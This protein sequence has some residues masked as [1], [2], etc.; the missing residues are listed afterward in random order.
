[1]GIPP[2][3][4]LFQRSGFSHCPGIVGIRTHTPHAVSSTTETGGAMR[5]RWCTSDGVAIAVLIICAVVVISLI[6][7]R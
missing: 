7:H 6:T 5:T 1:M 3:Q 4:H 2:G